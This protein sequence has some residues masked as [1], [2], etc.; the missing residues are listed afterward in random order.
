MPVARCLNVPM[1]DMSDA[2]AYPVPA[3][4]AGRAHAEWEL[5]GPCHSVGLYR[6]NL[7][8][9]LTKVLI[10]GASGML[11]HAAY[12]LFAASPGF[13]AVGSLRGTRPKG[14]EEGPAGRLI[15]GV[16]AANFDTVTRLIAS[17]RPDVVI[18]CVGVVKQLSAAK[19]PLT[20]IA[21]NALLPHRLAELCGA[22]RARLVHISTDCV[23]DGRK[24]GYVETDPS[25]AE[26]LYGK[27]KYLG[28][29]DYPHAVTLRTSIIGHE[30][31]SAV[32]LVDWFLSQPGPTV[33]GY[34]R[35]IYSGL[36]TVELAAV[37]RDIVIPRPHLRGVW[38]VVSDPIDKYALLKLVAKAY[39]KQVEIVPDDTVVVDRSMNGSRFR[40]ETGYV[41][42][43]WPQLVA[44]MRDAG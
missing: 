17:E 8:V 12:R 18:N 27:T 14:L 42:P 24:G 41:A 20:S 39:G 32:S 5:L 2:I 3:Q 16:D 10:F 13:E 9:A 1:L 35:A 6:G 43:P 40:T 38:H 31:S 15:G 33:K 7:G 44:R 34:R 19:D 23:F 21:V 29:V 26:D 37:I 4:S 36:P 22:A 28:E 11:G 25:N 30:L